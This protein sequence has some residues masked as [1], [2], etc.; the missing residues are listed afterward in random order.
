MPINS[1]LLPGAKFIPGYEVANSCRFEE[2]DSAY[3][4]ITPG[5][6]GHANIWTLSMWIKRST[7]STTQFLFGSSSSA[8]NFESIRINDDD[9][10]SFHRY[11]TTKQF[12]WDSIIKLRD[13]SAWYHLV[14]SRS[15]ATQKYYINGVEG[16]KTNDDT[17]TDTGD[18]N[19]TD[20][21]R[22][23]HRPDKAD[24]TN[25]FD[26]YMAEV[27]WI[28][29]TAYDADDFGE[30]DEDSPTIWK[31]KDASGLTFGTNGFYLDFEDSSNLG[32]D[33]NGGTD[34]TE[35]NL[36]ATDQT[37]DTPTNNFATFNPLVRNK[38]YNDGSL[39]EGNTYFAPGGRAIACS[40]IGVTSGKWYAEF[41][42]TDS[43]ALYIGVGDLQLGI[44]AN[45]GNPI[46]YDN[47]P[48]YAIGYGADG[49]IQ[50]NTT[51]SSYGS[52]Y[53][54]DDIIGVAL[55]MDNHALYFSVNGTWQN[56][57]DP[58]S[59]GS[60][61]GDATSEASYNPLDDGGEMFMFVSD[62]SA[63]GVGQCYV[64]FGNPAYANS[65]DAADADGYGAFEYAPPSGFYAL[66]S[67]NLAEYG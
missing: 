27:Y 42:A 16:A 2:G 49:S 28:D 66:C 67:K 46:F 47:N 7:L 22:L 18:F 43:G 4:H 51:S 10:L 1:F 40:S 65:S 13:P 39:A 31:P 3:M 64:N 14:F 29:G 55:D 23:C 60:K 11:L 48:S 8:S 58:T 59:A 5:S 44:Q 37:T 52:G 56:S 50:Y 9:T 41:K 33:A 36:A 24:G 62:F 6:A 63:A 25:H 15:G 54:D 26:G 32:N 34:L 12:G 21:H 57:G 30:F 61:T 53:S 38:D 20:E 17:S 35:V 19:T 45:Q